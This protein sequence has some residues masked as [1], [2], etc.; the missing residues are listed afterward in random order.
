M[1]DLSTDISKFNASMARFADEMGLTGGPHIQRFVAKQAIELVEELIKVSPPKEAAKTR[2]QIRTTIRHQF[3]SLDN[4]KGFRDSYSK[5]GEDSA[6]AGRGDVRWYFW[7]PTGLYG[8]KREQDLTGASVDELLKLRN[9]LRE[10][11]RGIKQRVGKRGKQAVFIRQKILTKAST[12]TKLFA[13]VIRHVGRLKAGWLPS[14]RILRGIVQGGQVNIPQMVLRHE[15][16][17]RGQCDLSGLGVPNQP[18]IT[19][20][21]YARGCSSSQMRFSA[22]RALQNRAVKMEKDLA[23]YVK[24]V[25]KRADLESY[26]GL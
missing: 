24:G 13:R 20:I 17:A 23:L 26:L 7:H 5:F 25:K 2:E 14:Y 1:I 12:V 16:K 15:D 11:K 6:K 21:N 10:G 19:L 9:T 18:T 3:E 8:V 4:D 22:H